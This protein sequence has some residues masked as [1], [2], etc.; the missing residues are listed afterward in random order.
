M[1][2]KIWLSSLFFLFN[3]STAQTHNLE[4]DLIKYGV[5]WNVEN[6]VE[7]YQ[8]N[9]NRFFEIFERSGESLYH[10]QLPPT[11]DIQQSSHVLYITKWP[12]GRVPWI[13][14]LQQRFKV[15][16]ICY[17]GEVSSSLF[18]EYLQEFLIKNTNF[19]IT[20]ITEGPVGPILQK[21]L[22]SSPQIP[23]DNIKK[24]VCTSECFEL[25]PFGAHISKDFL[26]LQQKF[27]KKPSI[28]LPFLQALGLRKSFEFLS[29]WAQFT[30][31]KW[32]DET[33]V[34]E[35]L[36]NRRHTGMT[37]LYRELLKS[38]EYA[39]FKKDFSHSKSHP[40]PS[41]VHIYSQVFEEVK[42]LIEDIK[43]KGDL[44]QWVDK[45]MVIMGNEDIYSSSKSRKIIYDLLG[46]SNRIN[47][48]DG[49]YSLL[50]DNPKRLNQLL[51]L[52]FENDN[53][54]L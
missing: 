14:L 16:T 29:L 6:W 5:E 18:A 2:L 38:E 7:Y 12:L 4:Q 34:R 11:V 32:G 1:F 53:D 25:S 52:I 40:L 51:E 17:L 36:V 37:R 8:N 43:E 41:D 3:I 33:L 24:I 10:T 28:A 13:K 50:S 22:L 54:T 39:K 31:L 21:V 46:I 30:L 23:T 20:L 26:S 42:G 15:V 48:S 49:R 27:L 19:P 9:I 47:L 45:L 44:P 35:H